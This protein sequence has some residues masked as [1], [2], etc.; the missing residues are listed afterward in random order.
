MCSL[1]EH[2]FSSWC[3]GEDLCLL[4]LV[5]Q[6]NHQSQGRENEPVQVFNLISRTETDDGNP[7]KAQP[8]LTDWY[9][10]N[11]PLCTRIL[12]SSAAF[13]LAVLTC[14]DFC[15]FCFVFPASGRWDLCFLVIWDDN[16]SAKHWVRATAN[17]TATGD[18]W[19]HTQLKDRIM[20]SGTTMGVS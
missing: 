19:R 15:C 13:I 4:C 12:I 11:S 10:K 2:C 17:Q 6:S 7:C 8:F 3:G 20:L 16:M 14:Y 5:L 18:V 1:V 9:C